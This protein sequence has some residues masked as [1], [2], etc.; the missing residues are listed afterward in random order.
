MYINLEV[1]NFCKSKDIRV[2]STQ[3]STTSREN[4][5]N[6]YRKKLV[7]ASRIQYRQS[8]GVKQSI[9]QRM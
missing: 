4:T 3:Q 7:V 9:L 8:H 2:E 6:N 1:E 5:W